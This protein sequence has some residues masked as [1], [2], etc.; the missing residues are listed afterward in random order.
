MSAKGPSASFDT[1]RNLLFGVLALQADLLDAG[2]F[3]EA[4]AVWAARKGTPLADLLVE[5]GWLTPQDRA[6]VERLLERKLRKHAGNAR[7]GLGAAASPAV[8]ETLA[9]LN[10]ADVQ[11]S[12]AGLPPPGDGGPVLPET[13]AYQPEA[14]GRYALTQL[15]ARGGIGQV[16]LARDA[17]LGR[18]VA[19]KEPRPD[20]SDSPAVLARF[21]EEARITGQLEHPGVVPVYEL[22]RRPGDRRP[23]YTM[24]FVKG[25][26]LAE[27]AH[28]FHARRQA[29]KSGILE[30]REL[31]GAFVAVCNAVA[32]AHSRGVLHR[33]L[34]GQ[35]VVLGDFGEVVVLDWGLAKLVGEGDGTV[36][37]APVT[38]EPGSHDETV[39]GQ[40]LGAPP[41][42]APEQAAGG[43]GRV[44]RRTDVYGLGALLYQVLTDDAPFSG[45]DTGEVLRKVVQE[46][47]VPPRQ[48]WPAMPV[49][50]EAV[51]LKALAKEPAARYATVRELADDVRRWLA[52]EPVAAYPDPITARVQRWGRRHR[53][54]VT[55]AAALLVA[56]LAALAAG[57]VLLGEANARTEQARREAEGQRDLARENF[58]KARQAVDDYFTQVSEN[59]LLKSPLP[60]LQPLRK[61]LLESA[62]RYYRAFAEQHQD[63]PAV[64]A[65]LA[66]A[67]Y[68]VGMITEE[69]GS[70]KEAAEA[71]DRSRAIR[72]RLAAADP[73]DNA[74]RQGLADCYRQLGIV[75]GQF[76]G[77][78]GAGLE[79][80]RRARDL[81]EELAKDH[82][83]DTNI[84]ASLVRRQRSYCPTSAGSPGR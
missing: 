37:G 68:R 12:L 19:L 32:Y 42:M 74:F 25:R 79:A 44:D 21:L 40:I 55:A 81:A 48:R 60:G 75:R 57:T 56:L 84:Q 18:D 50:L 58:D 10:D 78:P 4:C 30:L 51:C 38:V 80:L 2:R 43:P 29:G 59:K 61:E 52:D 47:P 62:L 41:F 26:T 64:Q 15:H 9:A 69:I 13:T 70:K 54:L 77:E 8:L 73:G 63:D 49:A 16:W 35:N 22:A 31:L 39:Q 66:Q 71:Y 24:R 36:L 1:D 7:A 14:R 76:L 72:E 45:A 67:Y 34:K 83:G 53:P 20:R 27:A 3:A 28:D 6:D 17:D 82:A 33:D 11:Q 23:F 65:E 46:A 5:R